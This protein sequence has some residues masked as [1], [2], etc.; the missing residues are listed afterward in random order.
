MANTIEKKNEAV[1]TEVLG[2][3]EVLDVN[4]V[5][6]REDVATFSPTV[7]EQPTQQIFST[8]NAETRADK[9]KVYNAVSNAEESLS[10]HIGEVIEVTDMVAH[11]VT[12][13]DEATGEEIQ[14]M[15]VVLLT[16]DG[17]GYHSVSQGIVQS[18]QR[19]IALVGMGPWDKEPLKIVPKQ[20]TTRRK[21]KTLTLQ[22]V[23]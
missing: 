13:M 2:N 4:E 23:D 5:S 10:E 17:V 18:L 19:I 3:K 9:I 15:R 8:I 20:V 11:P 12:L 21:F 6:V 16:A 14:A 22:L 7:F 1:D